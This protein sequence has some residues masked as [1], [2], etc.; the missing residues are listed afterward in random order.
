MLGGGLFVLAA[1]WQRF[2]VVGPRLDFEPIRGAPGWQSAVAGGFSGSASDAVFVGLDQ[3]AGLETTPPLPAHLLDD[4]LFGAVPDGHAPVAVFSDFFCPFCRGL[5]MRMAARDASRMHLRWHELPLLGPSSVI[6]AKSGVAA[7][8]QGQ[9]VSFQRALMQAPFRPTVR[10]MRAVAESAGLD[11]A[12]LM[13]DME[14]TAVAERLTQSEAAAKRLG[15]FATPGLVIGRKVVLG[16]I[17]EDAI[18]RLIAS[19]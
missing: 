2:G 19:A 15:I 17:G 3:A 10:H 14:G 12:R 9:Y 5:T 18:D 4:V 1:A 11:G 8:L 16:E 13:A 6:A 7:D